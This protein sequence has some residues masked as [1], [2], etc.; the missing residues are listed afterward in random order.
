MAL[1]MDRSQD[2]PQQDE[3]IDLRQYWLTLMRH[4]GGIL[5]FSMVVTLLSALVVFS[6]EPVYRATATLLI[7]SKQA[8]VVSIEEIYGLDASNSEYYMTQF[9]ILKSRKLAEMVVT[10]YQLVDHPE[11]N[12]PPGAF[13][14]DWRALAGQLLPDLLP[15]KEEPSA[16]RL[17]Q[18]QVMAFM[19][20]LTIAPVRKTQ[21]VKISFDAYDPHFAAKIANAL[22]EAYI[23]SNLD[24]KLQQTAKASSWL[25][26]RLG[27]LKDK[28]SESERLL[29]QF[30]DNE[31]IVGER[32]GLDIAGSE[33]SLAAAKLADARRERLEFESRYHQLKALGEKASP[34]SYERIP[35]VLSHPVVQSYKESM[36][37]VEQRESELAKRYGPKHPRMIAVIAEL[38]SARRLLDRQIISVVKGLENQYRVAV[39]NERALEKTLGSA[40]VQIQDL[41]RN[42]Y[43]L[44]QLELEVQTN[45]Q[46][47]DTF[48]TRL[49]ETA[50]TGSLAT[51]NA[52]NSDP[53]VAPNRPAKPKKKLIIALSAV[54]STLFGVLCAFLLEALNST[55]RSSSDVQEKLQQ[56]MLGLLPKLLDSKVQKRSYRQYI[57]DSKS[58]FSEAVRTI[59]TGL[60]LSSLDNPHRVI[61][62]TSTTPGEGKTTC[63][64]NLAYSL[65]QMER[66]LLLD[67]DMR[68]PSIGKLFQF[69]PTAPGLSNLVA[70]TATLEQCVH[71]LEEEGIDV[72]SAGII[73]PNPL[74]LLSSTKFAKVLEDLEQRYDRIVIDTAPCQAVSDALVLASRVGSM[75]Y[76]VKADSTHSTQIK[77]GLRRLAEVDAPL[78]GVIL[79][80][81]NLKKASRYYGEGYSGYYDTYG[82]G[83]DADKQPA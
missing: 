80:A 72:I 76:V 33:L 47:Y 50:A 68:R 79:N 78:V 40:K 21:L 11:F 81:V 36:L 24:S 48:F 4:K 56:P 70:G 15:A 53:A 35:A 8:N 77:A 41:K 13:T 39:N 38:S 52:R 31:D 5:G 63:A 25:H 16:E 10:K 60:V 30:R 29:Q 67:A 20:R 55:I 49:N 1:D 22:G 6:L 82:Y 32:G 61:A 27:G 9:E 2:G 69:G 7:E 43:Q 12:R 46:L 26:E 75:V 54:V 18:I 57:E 14:F 37:K 65:G 42:E 74:D 58:G 45:R 17:L 66:V 34:E 23:D 3:V 71:S 59:R 73:P 44:K 19:A 64:L 51:P 28:L 62:V 83:T